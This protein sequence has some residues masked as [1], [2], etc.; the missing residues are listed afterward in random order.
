M[1]A[2]EVGA[3]GIAAPAVQN[4]HQVDD[5]ILVFDE[6]SEVRIVVNVGFDDINGGQRHERARA[7]QSARRRRHAHTLRGQPGDDR[8]A[9][10]TGAAEYENSMK[11]HERRQ[12]SSVEPAGRGP[13]WPSQLRS[14]CGWPV[15]KA[16]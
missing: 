15:S 3:V 12:G 8:A 4:A 11:G 16:A 7:R 9:D 6:R 2:G 13:T 10:E 14:D 5:C 1:R